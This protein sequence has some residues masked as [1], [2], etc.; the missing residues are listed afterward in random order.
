MC[1]LIGVDDVARVNLTFISR[2]EL[3]AKFAA[4]VIYRNGDAG[5][6]QLVDRGWGLG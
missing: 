2:L 4:G 3:C 6:P 5:L 1:Q